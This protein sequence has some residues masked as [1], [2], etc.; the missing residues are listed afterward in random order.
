MFMQKFTTKDS[1][2]TFYNP[3]YNEYYHSKTG[4]VEEAVEKYAKPTKIAELARIGSL[5]IL[6]I[7]FGLGYNSCAA[8]DAALLANPDCLIE[9]TALEND[10]EI[11]SKIQAINPDFRHYDIIRALAIKKA[12]KKDNIKLEL[13]MGDAKK[14]IKNLEPGFDAVFLDPFSPKQQPEMWTENFFR[15]IHKLMKKGA[16]LA[17]YS[18]ARVVK[19]NLRQVGFELRDGP[20]VGR[21]S[22]ATLAVKI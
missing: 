14:T 3:K 7:C 22:P 16:I 20:K 1:S 5:R 19:D 8:I 15:D 2:V 12:Y 10:E 9:I 21:R 17:T 4:A 18:C 6:D 11:L 13:I